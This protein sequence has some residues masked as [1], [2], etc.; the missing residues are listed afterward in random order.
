MKQP[1]KYIANSLA[2]RLTP[3]GIKDALK[4]LAAA[5]TSGRYRSLV[6]ERP[7][8]AGHARVY[9]YHI[10]KTAGTSVNHAFRSLG[11]EDPKAVFDRCRASLFGRTVSGGRVFVAWNRPL[12]EQGYYHYASSHLPY[13][14]LA[15]PPGTFTLTCF[16]DPADRV[17]SHWKMLRKALDS[18]LPMPA[19][20]VEAAWMGD[21]FA[22]F[23]DRAP[24]SH[25]LNQL[26]MFSANFNVDE[27]MERI[28]SLNSILFVD[29]LA[30]DLTALGG[31]IGLELQV[32]QANRSPGDP[33]AAKDAAH[34]REILAPEYDLMA[35]VRKM[36][37]RQ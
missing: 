14:Q 1:P 30:E 28:G 17:Y 22:E 10:R 27:A 15:L 18:N 9:H 11:G 8:A 20:H 6:K 25:V 34:L 3:V 2:A 29:T 31:R 35:R 26:Y 16:R 12:I 32:L 24:C 21:S 13:D 36:L 7:L 4:R 23:L 33:M 19:L 37:E 5:A